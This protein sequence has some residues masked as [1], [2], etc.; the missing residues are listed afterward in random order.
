MYVLYEH[1]ESWTSVGQVST[2]LWLS[3]GFTPSVSHTVKK[4]GVVLAQ[5]AALGTVTISIRADDGT[6]KPTLGDLDSVSFSEGDLPVEGSI[7]FIEK[8]LP[9][10]VPVIAG[11]KYHIVIR[12]TDNG[13]YY[14]RNL[15]S[16]PYAGGAFS[17]S[18]DGGSSW[19]A[20]VNDDLPFREYASTAVPSVSSVRA[21]ASWN[22]VTGIGNITNKGGYTVTK[23]G[24]A[25]NT[26]GGDPDP[27]VDDKVEEEGDFDTGSFTEG[28]PNL[29]P[30]TTYYVRP[31]AYSVEEGYGYG[32]TL[33]VTTSPSS[34]VIA[35]LNSRL[36]GKAANFTFADMR[37]GG[38]LV[39]VIDP[40]ASLPVN[41]C[42]VD[43]TYTASPWLFRTFFYFDL[44]GVPA[45]FSAVN[46]V[47]WSYTLGAEFEELHVIEGVQDFEI[48]TIANWIS[49]NSITTKLGGLLK[50]GIATGQYVTV[51]LNS[52]GVAF[53]KSKLGGYCKLCLMTLDDF[54]NNYNTVVHGGDWLFYLPHESGKEPYLE[55]SLAG[56]GNLADVL[57]KGNFI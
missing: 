9:T 15:G 14:A 19:T 30:N 17:Y 40:S 34:K 26:T 25:Y 32:T 5:L 4:I 21:T 10:G 47:V 45:G 29:L 53:V 23:R 56:G 50:A 39:A 51:P 1:Y 36:M 11:T 42:G 7:G 24:V 3:Q 35:T 43:D 44:R 33:S 16:N 13:W 22:T 8:N 49:Q 18:T 52:D 12:N 28:I 55:F 41:I 31:Y 37:A 38:G 57:V 2:A 20:I 46:L 6:G 48:P 27:T 54:D